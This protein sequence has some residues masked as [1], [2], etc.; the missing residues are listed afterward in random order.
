[1]GKGKTRV[2]KTDLLLDIFCLVDKID[3]GMDNLIQFYKCYNQDKQKKLW[4]TQRVLD[5]TLC[6]ELGKAFMEG[7]LTRLILERQVN[8]KGKR[9]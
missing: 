7:I 8:R 3:K 2:N 9:F 1:M 4:K 6:W 5:Y